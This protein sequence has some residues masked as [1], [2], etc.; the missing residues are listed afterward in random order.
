MVLAARWEEADLPA[1]GA[2]L[3]A[4]RAD[5]QAVLV[6]GPAAHWKQF[7]PQLLA[8][9]HERGSGTAL[10]GWLLSQPGEGLERRMA[11]LAAQTG[12]DSCAL[13]KRQCDPRCGYFGP[14]GGPLVMDDAHF[15][16]EASLLFAR[17]FLRPA[18][19][20]AGP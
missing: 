4:L 20:R 5:G 19:L 12:A 9:G 1:L 3:T 8:L 17:E 15:T 7:V 10:A 16:H 13:R 18:L 14:F 6:V 11:Q 2:L